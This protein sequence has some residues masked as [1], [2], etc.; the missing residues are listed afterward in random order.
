MSRTV[1]RQMLESDLPGVI[2][3]AERVH[4]S[5]PE[6]GAI[7]AE[8]LKLYPLGCYV[9][10]EI[11]GKPAGYIISHPWL[12]KSPPKLNTLLLELPVP[13]TTF[14]IHDI[15]LMPTARAAGMAG[16]IV[17]TITDHARM[18]GFPNISLIAVNQSVSFWE[19]HAFAKEFDAR[20]EIT[21]RSYDAGATF[22]SRKLARD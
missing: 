5:Y 17:E 21:L 4:I 9:L 18:A 1:W 14:Y 7:F 8:R 11:Q 22:M 19:R 15:A 3:I 2:A 13:A 16:S 12:Y 6:D 10:Q 20:L